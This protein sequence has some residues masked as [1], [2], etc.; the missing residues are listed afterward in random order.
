MRRFASL[1]LLSTLITAMAFAADSGSGSIRLDSTVKVGTTELPP[2][3][4]KVKWTGS[5]ANTEV[6][7]TQGK[8]KV[9]APA[10]VVEVRRNNDGIATKSDNGSRVLT[11]IQFQKQT[12]VL[13]NSSS[14]IAGQ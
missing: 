6:T 4:Y 1:M 5:G 14:Q 3:D 12:L 7:L 13:Q 11:E 9:T 2:G 10:Q 8:T